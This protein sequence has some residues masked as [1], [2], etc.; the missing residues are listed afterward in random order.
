VH[1]ARFSGTTPVSDKLEVGRSD[2]NFYIP[3]R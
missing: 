1:A 3:Q 2:S